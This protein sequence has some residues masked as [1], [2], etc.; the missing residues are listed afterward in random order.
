MR[1]EESAARSEDNYGKDKG[2]AGICGY[3]GGSIR[4]PLGTQRKMF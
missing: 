2:L 1:T 4:L 3:D